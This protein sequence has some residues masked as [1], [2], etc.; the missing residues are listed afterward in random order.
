MKPA[1]ILSAVLIVLKNNLESIKDN[2]LTPT[3]FQAAKSWSVGAGFSYL[4]AIRLENNL[5]LLYAFY[6]IVYS[7]LIYCGT[8]YC[9]ETVVIHA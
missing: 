8:F 2:F 1:L 5:K 3:G 9:G 6:Q 7:N 4:D